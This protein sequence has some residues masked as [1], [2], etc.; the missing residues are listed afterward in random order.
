MLTAAARPDEHTPTLMPHSQT[1][2]QPYAPTT[3]ASQSAALH[4]CAGAA[5][6]VSLTVQR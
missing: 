4:Y 2:R 3:T 6:E 1:H 5:E